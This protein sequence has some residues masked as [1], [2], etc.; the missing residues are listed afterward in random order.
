FSWIL[1]SVLTLLLYSLKFLSL[2]LQLRTLPVNLFLLLLLNFLLPLEL[3]SNKRTTSR[4]KRTTDES[5]GN[6]MVNSTT[7]KTPGSGSA[8]SSDCSAFLC[9]GQISTAHKCHYE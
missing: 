7:D 3:V 6:R 4:P 2:P 8:Q 1:I 9:S 5:P